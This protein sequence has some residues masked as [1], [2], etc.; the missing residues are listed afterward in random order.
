[1]LE[2]ESVGCEC[3][4]VGELKKFPCGKPG[5]DCGGWLGVL[6]DGIDYERKAE[7]V[8]SIPEL[9]FKNFIKA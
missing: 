6:W 2:G 9:W 4:A 7:P 5:C 8:L 1:M 3:G